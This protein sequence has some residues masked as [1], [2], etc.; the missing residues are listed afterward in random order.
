[1]NLF[2]YHQILA[3]PV[4]LGGY[5]GPKLMCRLTF[6][7]AQTMAYNKQ[8]S[9]DKHNYEVEINN[10][11]DSAVEMHKLSMLVSSLFLICFFVQ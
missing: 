1:M 3:G 10:S 2:L 8:D 9:N 5:Q 4:S 6:Q 11:K 7:H